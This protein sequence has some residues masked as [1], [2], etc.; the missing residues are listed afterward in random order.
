MKKSLTPVSLVFRKG[1]EKPNKNDL[2]ILNHLR[3]SLLLTDLVKTGAL[4]F[5][6]V[7]CTRSVSLPCRGG[8][9][10]SV[11]NNDKSKTG[12]VS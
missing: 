5:A 12:V 3:F 6:S 11:A 10:R 8:L 9:P 2:Q 7:T 1:Y 4:S